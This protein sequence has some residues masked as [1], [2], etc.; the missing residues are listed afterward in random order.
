MTRSASRSAARL[1]AIFALLCATLAQAGTPPLTT[2]TPF[3][4]S[5]EVRLNNLPFKAQAEQTLTALGGDRWR[6]EV[7][8]DSFLLDTV[9]SSEFRWD[10]N[11][12]HAIPEH[13]RYTRKGIGRN[14]QLDL[15]FDSAKRLATRNDGR[16]TETFAISNRTEDKMAHTLALG[17]RIARG[18]RG[19]LS[20]EVAWDNKVQHFDYRVSASEEVVP[21]PAGNWRALRFERKRIDNERT[22]TSWVAAAANWQAVKMQ[23]TEG[24]GNLIQLRLLEL[25]EGVQRVAPP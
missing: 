8:L 21:T 12:C 1:V 9:E 24:D 4:A 2:L 18:A 23:H 5:Y 20:V 22:T 13:Y 3:R 16:K 7:R 10:G 19:D 25:D 15:Q 14:K 6:L 17:C 11:N